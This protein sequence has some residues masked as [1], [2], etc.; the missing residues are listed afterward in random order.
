MQRHSQEPIKQ[1][2]ILSLGR[3]IAL[4]LAHFAVLF[5]DEK[6]NPHRLRWRYFPNW[7]GQN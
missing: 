1:T 3:S 7:F 5:A 4:S 2:L 6:P